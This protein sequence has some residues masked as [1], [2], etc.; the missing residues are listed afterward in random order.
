MNSCACTLS[1]TYMLYLLVVILGWSKVTRNYSSGCKRRVQHHS[2]GET[3]SLQ[4][5]LLYILFFSWTRKCRSEEAKMLPNRL[6][7][8]VWCFKCIYECAPHNFTYQKLKHLYMLLCNRLQVESFFC[9]F[10]TLRSIMRC[11]YNSARTSF[12][13]YDVWLG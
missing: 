11:T 2:R 8:S 10:P 1:L 13:P 9:G 4:V 6:S 7:V 12:S 5:E 3:I